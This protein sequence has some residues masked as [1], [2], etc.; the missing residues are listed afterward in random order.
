[1]LGTPWFSMEK[2]SGVCDIFTPNIPSDPDGIA[3]G[4]GNGV[5]PYSDPFKSYV[6]KTEGV[7][8]LP[9]PPRSP[10]VNI[11]QRPFLSFNLTCD[12]TWRRNRRYVT[13]GFI[14]NH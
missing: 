6:K 5:L 10:R 12:A 13:S 3:E 8:N 9:P 2:W 4:I 14:K 11:D 1:V 7:A